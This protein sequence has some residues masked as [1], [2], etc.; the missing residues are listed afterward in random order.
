[1]NSGRPAYTITMVLVL[2]TVAGSSHVWGDPGLD[3]AVYSR[4]GPGENVFAGLDYEPY[5]PDEFPE[6]A[7]QL[8]RYET[9]FFGSL[10]F[11]FLFT[12]LGFDFYAYA[13]ND[14]DDNYLPLFLGTSPEK[15][16][17]NNRT[18]GARIAVS[19]SLSAVI[20]YIDYLIERK[21]DEASP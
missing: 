11:A 8:R 9:I 20:A 13:A 6:W 1:M 19:I 12:S 10:P 4:P 7:H 2:L 5:S 17:F 14:F 16:D 15:E 18:I 21:Q 3:S